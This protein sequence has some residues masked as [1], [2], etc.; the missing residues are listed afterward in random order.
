MNPLKPAYRKFRPQQKKIEEL[1]KNNPRFKRIY[2]EYETMS[3]DLWD[4]ENSDI[5]GVPDD[6]ITAMKQQTEYL[7][8]EIEDWLEVK[9][10]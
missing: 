2:T 10:D 3:D 1:E 4:L 5:S 9:K 7:E 8:V 6:F